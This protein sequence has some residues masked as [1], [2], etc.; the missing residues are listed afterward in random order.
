VAR[1]HTRREIPNFTRSPSD[2]VEKRGSSTIN[3]EVYDCKVAPHTFMKNQWVLEKNYN[4]LHKN[5]KLVA[6]HK[7]P[8]Q[9]VRVLPHNKV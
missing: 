2:G 6:K 7:G 9:I 3:Q 1:K 4:Y 5:T 8:Y